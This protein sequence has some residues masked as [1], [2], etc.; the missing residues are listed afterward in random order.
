M[1]LLLMPNL[2]KQHIHSCIRALTEFAARRQVELLMNEKYAAC[3]ADCGGIRCGEFFAL[4]EEADL[5]VA[6]GGDGTI[7]HMAK[8]A[9]RA[10]KPTLGIN[11]G[12]LGFLAALERDQLSLLDQLLTGDYRIEE[13]MMLE[14]TLER[15]EERLHFQALNDAVISKGALSRMI[16]VEVSNQGRPVGVYRADGIIAATPTGSTAYALSAGGPIIDPCL[17]CIALTPIS[18]Q[19]LFSRSILFDAASRIVIQPAGG[20]NQEIFLTVDGE[21][22]IPIQPGDRLVIEKSPLAVRLLNLTG[23]AFYEVLNEKLLCRAHI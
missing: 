9:A 16:E 4:L 14:I 8:H 21:E 3:F 2:D 17:S 18:A 7:I 5:C 1:K 22:G 13:R 23:K 20:E 19:S 11:L 12:R 15:G 6:V 10:G